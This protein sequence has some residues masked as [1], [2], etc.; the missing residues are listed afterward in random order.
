MLEKDIENSIA[1]YPNE[2]FPNSGFKLIGQ[3]EWMS[4]NLK[5][6]KLNDGT[7]IPN[8]TDITDWVRTT[9]PAYCWYDNDISNKAIYGG[10]Y[11]WHTVNTGKLCP[12]R[13]HVPTDNDWNTL[14]KYIGGKDSVVKNMEEFGF[15][16]IPGGYRYGYYWGSGIFYEKDTNAYLWTSTK[17]T[18][19]HI[20][21]RTISNDFSIIYRSYFTRN[22][23]FSVRCIKSSGFNKK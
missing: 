21:S 23:G 4:G 15:P 11:N 2:F 6:T 9:S 17:A 22:N 3:L 13:W 19:T 7:N 18:D 20:W 1:Q 8:I 12:E 10:L 14:L 5:S 16:V